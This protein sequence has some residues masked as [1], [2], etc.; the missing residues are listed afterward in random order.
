ERLDSLGDHVDQFELFA[1]VLVE[2]QVQLVE[3]RAAHQPVVLLVQRVQD[4]RISERLI[5][6]LAGE[7]PC[8]VGQRYGELPDCAELL[9]LN[10]LLV[11]P[12][13]AGYRTAV[14]ARSG[15]GHTGCRAPGTGG[16]TLGRSRRAPCGGRAGTLG[17]QDISSDTAAAQ[18]KCLPACQYAPR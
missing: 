10:P 18:L 9:E 11:Q 13:L 15:T 1:G 14:R 3:G 17:G 5:K 4:L 16:R 12:R 2:K 6:K 7:H 8:V